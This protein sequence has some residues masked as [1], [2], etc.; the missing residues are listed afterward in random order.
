MRRRGEED[1][2]IPLRC[3]KAAAMTASFSTGLNE[4]VEYTS[5]PPGLSMSMARLR[6]RSCRLS[7]SCFSFN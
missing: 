5:L 6:I 2:D 3:F 4:Q 1:V 7:V